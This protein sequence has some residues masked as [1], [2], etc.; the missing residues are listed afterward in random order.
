[1]RF[2][3]QQW[4][5]RIGFSHFFCNLRNDVICDIIEEAVHRLLHLRFVS[6]NVCLHVGSRGLD[7]RKSSRK[8]GT[9]RACGAKCVGHTALHFRL[10]KRV[11]LVLRCSS[12][13][14]LQGERRHLGSHRST[15]RMDTCACTMA[16]SRS[17]ETS[18]G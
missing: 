12:S 11:P 4:N 16:S 8:G 6:A 7:H 2:G 14:F 15:S 3:N 5:Q 13:F 1:M 18:M 9:L 10:E 17:S